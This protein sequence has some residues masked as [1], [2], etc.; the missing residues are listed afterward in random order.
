MIL[1]EK[2]YASESHHFYHRDGTPCYEV[3]NKSKGGMRPTT[4]RDARKLGLLPS[5]STILG[6]VS[7]PGLSGW[8]KE[9]VAKAAFGVPPQELE[10][11]E[12]WVQYVLERAETNMNR[13]R[14]LGTEIH[15]AIESYLVNL[16]EC[17]GYEAQWV[18]KAHS[19]HIKA[20]VEALKEFGVWGEPF[21]AEKSFASLLGYGGKVD[22]SGSKNPWIVD[23]KGVDRLEKKLDYPDRC[24]QCVAYAYGV[25]PHLELS[26][27]PCA[28]IFICTSEPG[29]YL[30]REWSEEE[31]KKGWE[32]FRAAQNLWCASQNYYP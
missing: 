20:A 9:Q 10:S 18:Q 15:G 32:V 21:R 13:A 22:L 30:L 12:E 17:P 29:T 27:V 2:T 1:E 28:N 8:M 5:V 25:Y 3:E 31:K 4:V 6:I 23:F 26:T 19:Q 14:D 16:E 11:E 7:K 24:Q